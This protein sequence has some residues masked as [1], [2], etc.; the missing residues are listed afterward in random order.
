MKMTEQEHWDAFAE[1]TA[2]RGDVAEP[3]FRWTQYEGHGPEE[4]VLGR[5]RS[6]LELGCGSGENVVALVRKGFDA[7]GVDLSPVQCRLA[8]ERWPDVSRSR[9]IGAEAVSYLTG[10]S[11]SYDAMYSVFGAVWFTS[12]R[13]LLPVVRQRL[14]PGGLLAFSHPPAIDGCYG[15]QGMYRGGFTGKATF[16]RRHCY[17][18]ELW[19][20]ILLSHG[21]VDVRAEVIPAPQP[22]HIGTLLVQATAAPG[23]TKAL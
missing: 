11:T 8:A 10:T 13:E 21:F 23:A 15:P 17:T 5:P 20:G 9:F 2:A 19:T 22:G 16:L 18:P 1:K 7:S 12:P 3:V 4:E 6:V 14:V